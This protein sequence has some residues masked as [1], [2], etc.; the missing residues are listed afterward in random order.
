MK[1]PCGNGEWGRVGEG[2]RGRVGE[3]EK[4]ENLQQPDKN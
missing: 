4:F 3:W 2:E 1:Q